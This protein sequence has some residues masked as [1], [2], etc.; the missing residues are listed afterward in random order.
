[1]TGEYSDY[2][3]GQEWRSTDSTGVVIY[4]QGRS[5]ITWLSDMGSNLLG[6][7]GSERAGQ[8]GWS[9]RRASLTIN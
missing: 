6:E 4:W 1:M 2:L 3:A 8:D 5:V 7:S 9:C